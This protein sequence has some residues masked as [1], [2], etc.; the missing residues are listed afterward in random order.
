[1]KKHG[2]ELKEK[3]FQYSI[4]KFSKQQLLKWLVEYYQTVFLDQ[5]G[6]RQVLKR[7]AKINKMADDT[8]SEEQQH[9]CF[10]KSLTNNT[11]L[12][13]LLNEF[14]EHLASQIGYK[15]FKIISESIHILKQHFREKEINFEKKLEKR[16]LSEVKTNFSSRTDEMIEAL[17]DTK[18]RQH[19]AEIEYP[20]HLKTRQIKAYL[21]TKFPSAK[22]NFSI[23]ILRRQ[24][25]GQHASFFVSP[26]GSKAY[27]L[28]QNDFLLNPATMICGITPMPFDLPKNLKILSTIGTL[29]K[30]EWIM[31]L[32]LAAEFKIKKSASVIPP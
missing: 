32:S 17:S 20:L 24:R 9:D 1:M 19:E 29:P 15:S 3:Y 6:T 28:M 31:E 5:N 8:L 14:I 26:Q 27:A 11:Q 12:S 10:L 4:N 18:A 2:E 7:Y 13:L 23:N 22:I 21:A 16:V 25:E 30:R